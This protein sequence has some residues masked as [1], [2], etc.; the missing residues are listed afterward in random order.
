[1]DLVQELTLEEKISLLS[2]QDNWSVAGI[3]RIGLRSI[4]TSDGPVGVRGTDWDDRKS[5]A[6]T[7]SPT[8]LA[9]TWN[10]DLMEQ[11][12]NLLARE[13]GKKGVDVI[14]AP[15]INLHRTPLGGRHFEC[16]SEDPVLTGGIAASYVRGNPGRRQGRLSE[17]FRRKRS[18]NRPPNR[19]QHHRRTRAA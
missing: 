7:P 3:E 11:V 12:G 5:S 17:A 18:G 4:V 10:D 15:T 13:A 1:M 16:F 8:G 2:G 6:N 9:A 14:L 19:E